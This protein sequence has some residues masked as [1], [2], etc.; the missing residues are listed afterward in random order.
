MS[1]IHYIELKRRRI[2]LYHHRHLQKTWS[3]NIIKINILAKFD[4]PT[5]NV[6]SENVP[7]AIISFVRPPF[8]VN[9]SCLQYRRGLERESGRNGRMCLWHYA[10]PTFTARRFSSMSIKCTART[11]QIASR[12]IFVV[13]WFNSDWFGVPLKKQLIISL[14]QWQAVSD[15]LWFRRR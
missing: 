7:G 10:A 1:H 8:Y 2:R 11:K 5:T 15:K 4:F 13:K 9:A 14:I 3:K 6:P 12:C